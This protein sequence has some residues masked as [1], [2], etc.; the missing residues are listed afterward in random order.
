MALPAACRTQR[1]RRRA[2]GQGRRAKRAVAA[3]SP[4]LFS[5]VQ[6]SNVAGKAW[7]AGKFLKRLVKG[8]Q[9]QA[10]KLGAWVYQWAWQWV[11]QCGVGWGGVGR[12]NRSLPSLATMPLSLLVPLG[13]PAPAPAPAARLPAGLRVLGTRRR[14]DWLF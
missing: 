9:E 5:S 6:L 2:S 10:D 14:G 3:L 12:D 4:L 7:Y 13:P 1:L 11:W 8:R